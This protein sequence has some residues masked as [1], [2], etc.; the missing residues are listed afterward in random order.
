M[1]SPEGGP[2]GGPEQAFDFTGTKAALLNR[3]RLLA[4]LRDDRPELRWP[5][6][7]DLPGGGREGAETPEQ[8]LLR[9]VEEEFGLRLT[10]GRLHHRRLW[11]AMDGGGLPAVF[12]AV[13]L[14]DAEVGLIRLGNEGQC[15]QMMPVDDYLAHPRAIQALCQRIRA[16]PGVSPGC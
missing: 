7:W 6:M 5:G 13:T 14:T 2:E 11:P 3:G 4:Y 8:C 16:I 9:E 10:A 1:T 15:W 12:F